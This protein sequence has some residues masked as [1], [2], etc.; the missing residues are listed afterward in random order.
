MNLQHPYTT[1]RRRVSL[2][3]DPDKGRTRSDMADECDINQ[4]MAKATKTGV[5]THVRTHGLHY[6]DYEGFDFQH[7]MQTIREAQ[8]MFMELPARA[9][10]MFNNSPEEFLGYVQDPDNREQ[11][12]RLGLAVLEP[13]PEPSPEPAPAPEP[14][15]E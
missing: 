8:E 3:F 6:G 15:P 12:E 11:L 1:L 10:A 14:G 2:E 4:I 7:A 13:T 5:V 9:R